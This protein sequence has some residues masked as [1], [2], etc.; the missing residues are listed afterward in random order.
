[1]AI[2]AGTRGSKTVLRLYVAGISAR[3][4]RAVQIARRLCDEGAD[5]CE[6]TVVDV[7]QQPELAKIDHIE[8][9]P[10]LVKKLPA[11]S[12]RVTGDLSD[13]DAVRLGLG[14]EPT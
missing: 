6:L 14:L 7:F 12:R 10:T 8:A 9:V 5:G 1:M 13:L 4:T 11:P 2:A 3:S